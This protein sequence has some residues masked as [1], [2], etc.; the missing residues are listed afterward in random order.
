MEEMLMNIFLL[1]SV[2]VGLFMFYRGAEFVEAADNTLSGYVYRMYGNLH[3][4]D[5][6]IHRALWLDPC[7]INAHIALNILRNFST[8]TRRTTHIHVTI[9]V[10]FF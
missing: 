2:P 3:C 7:H 5:V 8:I 4:C 1:L 10:Y 6:Y 9:F